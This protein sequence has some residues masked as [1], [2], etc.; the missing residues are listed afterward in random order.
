MTEIVVHPTNADKAWAATADGGVFRTTNGGTTW[1][2]VAT[3]LGNTAK[4]MSLA[5][6]PNNPEVLYAGTAD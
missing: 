1:Q 6:D 4:V 2:R 5:I 3:G